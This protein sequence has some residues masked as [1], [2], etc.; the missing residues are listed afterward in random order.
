MAVS[1]FL[2]G[3]VRQSFVRS[4]KYCV[5]YYGVIHLTPMNIRVGNLQPVL[6]HIIDELDPLCSDFL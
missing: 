1:L 2:I 3:H 5:K 6:R 4:R